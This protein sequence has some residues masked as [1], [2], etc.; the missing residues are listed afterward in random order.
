M[1]DS[2]DGR[3]DEEANASGIVEDSLDEG[4]NHS[5]AQDGSDDEQEDA[6]EEDDDEQQYD[7]FQLPIIRARNR[8]GFEPSADWRPRIGSLIAGRYRVQLEI[9]EAVFSRT[10]KCFDEADEQVVCLKIIKNSKEYFDQ[11]VDEIR[12]L[13]F[14]ASNCDVDEK[15]L[16]RL[17]DYFYFREH[18]IIVTELLRDNLYEFSKLLS[19]RGHANY[20]TIPRLK[21]VACQILEALEFLHSLGLVHCDLKPEN[22]LISNF[23][24]CRIKVIDFGSSC[25]VTDEL[26]S[27]VQSRSYRAPE[28]ILGLEYDQKIDI[29]SLGCV[30]AEL[31]TGDVLFKNNSEQSLLERIIAAIGPV[32]AD[33]LQDQA[34]LLIQF[35]E[36]PVFA[37]DADGCGVL[38]A[39]SSASRTLSLEATLQTSDALFVDF[40]R[41]LLRIHP[42]ERLSASE[43]LLHPWLQTSR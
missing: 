42:Q 23:N 41:S 2:D 36:N 27:Y 32:P 21:L 5:T 1:D 9:G 19:E 25:F 17:I 30:L 12:V 8:T 14:I 38:G 3:S 7:V 40:L 4:E 20:F 31:F 43:A 16:V 37:L 10:Y 13:Q 35:T 29:W 22:I 34:D 11:G 28:V 15:H 39:A 6:H 18:L 24:E 26:T 33:L